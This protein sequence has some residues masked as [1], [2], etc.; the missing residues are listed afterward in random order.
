[1][2]ASTFFAL[3]IAVLLGFAFLGAVRYFG[4]LETRTTTK[5]EVPVKVEYPKILVAKT[6]LFEGITLTTANVQV[7]EIRP[8]EKQLLDD[9]KKNRAKYPDPTAEAANF[10]VMRRNVE[11]GQVLLKDDF[12]PMVIPPGLPARITD[13]MVA[14]NV[15]IPKEQAASG[16]IRVDDYVDVLLTSNITA[17]KGNPIAGPRT[18]CIA[19]D[20][21]VIIKRG[22]LGTYL[23]PVPDKLQFT[24]EADPYRATLITYAVDKGFLTLVPSAKKPRD[25]NAKREAPA[26]F[27]IQGSKE[28]KN[29]D[30]RVAAILRSDRSISDGD[31]ER[32]FGLPPLPVSETMKIE[33]YTGNKSQNPVQYV[34]IL[35]PEDRAPVNPDQPNYGYHFSIPTVA[36][37]EAATTT[38]PVTTFPRPVAAPPAGQKKQ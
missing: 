34:K 8:E 38:Q 36:T 14:V 21:C 28:Y 1:M 6:N 31:L 10:R 12:E 37:A 24:L 29:E 22:A 9:Y 7:R 33:T 26:T 25:P 23:A 3:F 19:R 16:L 20:L 18:A 15:L 30:E 11:A 4:W 32:I 13:K 27:N 2:R 5:V 17:D 35:N